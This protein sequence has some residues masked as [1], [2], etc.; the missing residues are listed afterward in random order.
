MSFR[1]D[2][3]DRLS[4]HVSVPIPKDHDGFLGRECPQSECEGYFKIK[5]GT[6]LK[7]PD[8]PC[9]CPYCGHC[10][11]QNSFWTKDQIAYARSVVLR[12]VADALRKDLKQLEVEHKPQGPFGI[13][14]SVKLQHGPPLPIRYY[15]EK[16]LETE[17]T[18][19]E[20]ALEYSVFGVFGYCPDCGIHNSFQI[21][22]RNLALTVKELDLAS[23]QT[24]AELR[25]HLV[26][27]ALENCVSAFDAFAR[28]TCRVRSAKSAD[29]SQAE[30]L[31]FQNLPRAAQRLKLLFAIDI[32]QALAPMEWQA[33]HLGFMRRHLLAHKGG[34][35]DRQYLNETGEPS[36]LLGRRLNIAPDEVRALAR[37]V[38]TTGRSL[39]D[40]LPPVR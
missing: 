20:C 31:S 11:S 27:D 17:V 28:E 36:E 8:L 12:D 35:V 30:A 1:F 29:S 15:R 10:G 40:L 7:G 4:N 5:P 19:D 16:S 13:G 21:L 18:C 33:A 37:I 38:E 9:Y 26:E 23:D 14:F 3:L 25:R 32:S 6:G 22:Q 2:H 39:I 24:D 34:V